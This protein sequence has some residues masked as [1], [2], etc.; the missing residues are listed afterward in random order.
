MLDLIVDQCPKYVI[1]TGDLK[2]RFARDLVLGD[3]L[4]KEIEKKGH[5]F[6]INAY[7]LFGISTG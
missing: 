4:Y 3:F 5:A 2:L 1:D 6:S 7:V